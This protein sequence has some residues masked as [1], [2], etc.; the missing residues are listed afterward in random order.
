[1]LIE[2]LYSPG[3]AAISTCHVSGA[4]S[5]IESGCQFEKSP[6]IST[7]RAPGMTIV[8]RQTP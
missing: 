2:V 4:I 8:I 6:E 5:V 3:A 7:V 1:M